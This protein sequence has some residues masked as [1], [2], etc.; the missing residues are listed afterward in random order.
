M[1]KLSYRYNQEGKCNFSRFRNK[2]VCSTYYTDRLLGLLTI[3]EICLLNAFV[4]KSRSK[5]TSPLSSFSLI[6]AEMSMI[7][8]LT[9]LSSSSE[10]ELASSTAGITSIRS[11]CSMATSVADPAYYQ[12]F[13]LKHLIG[14]PLSSVD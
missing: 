2:N 3:L 5:L 6:S 13:D 7:S 9:F 10:M 4:T 12:S 14:A 11:S 1:P 8:N